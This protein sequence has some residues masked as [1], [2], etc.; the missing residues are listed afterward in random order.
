MYMQ[1]KFG[2]KS[3]PNSLKR[4][5][6]N[7]KY[8]MIKYKNV[9]FKQFEFFDIVCKENT[10]KEENSTAMLTDIPISENK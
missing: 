6:L 2:I 10:I 9:M 3:F 5:A 1:I 7:K 4:Y 8:N